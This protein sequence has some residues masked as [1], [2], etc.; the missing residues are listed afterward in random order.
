MSVLKEEPKVAT[1]VKITPVKEHLSKE[2]AYIAKE[3]DTQQKGKQKKVKQGCGVSWQLASS[4]GS[5]VGP[6]C[7]KRAYALYPVSAWQ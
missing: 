4:W 1:S 2:Q 3:R 7:A 6:D 5:V